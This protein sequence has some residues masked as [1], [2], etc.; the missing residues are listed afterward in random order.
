[1]TKRVVIEDE[2]GPWGQ[3]HRLYSILLN[4]KTK[5]LLRPALVGK[6]WVWSSRIYQSTARIAGQIP[7]ETALSQ[8]AQPYE[9]RRCGI[10]EAVQ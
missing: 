10:T 8:G 9:K 3:S 6:L 2:E 1:L 4:L 7:P 5:V